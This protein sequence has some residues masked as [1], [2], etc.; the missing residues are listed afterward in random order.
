MKYLWFYTV[1]GMCILQVSPFSSQT[2][3]ETNVSHTFQPS[4]PVFKCC[5]NINIMFFSIL[6]ISEICGATVIVAAAAWVKKSSTGTAVGWVVLVLELLPPSYPP[7]PATQSIITVQYQTKISKCR[8]V[9]QPLPRIHTE[10]CALCRTS[11]FVFKYNRNS[12]T[13]V[14]Y[15]FEVNLL[16]NHELW[17]KIM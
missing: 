4:C 11:Y 17:W 2:T 5:L 12:S 10:K 7:A 15:L 8:S 14:K 9:L 3:I 16:I 13:A 1:T 6:C